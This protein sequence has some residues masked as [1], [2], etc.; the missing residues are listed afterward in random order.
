MGVRACVIDDELLVII[1]DQPLSGGDEGLL[2]ESFLLILFGIGELL[3][4][5]QRR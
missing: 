1:H 5:K 2:D 4:I 3:L